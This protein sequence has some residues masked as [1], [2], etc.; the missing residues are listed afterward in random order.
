MND[1]LVTIVNRPSPPDGGFPDWPTPGQERAADLFGRD[2]DLLGV[3]QV[4]PAVP[5]DIRQAYYTRMTGWERGLP[6]WAACWEIRPA[7]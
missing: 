5:C 7:C 2:P 4:D 3:C 6:A 1:D